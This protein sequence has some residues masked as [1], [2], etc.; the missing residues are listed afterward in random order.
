MITPFG[1]DVTYEKADDGLKAWVSSN[2]RPLVLPF[3]DR[4]ISS[5]FHEGLDAIT[6]YN[7]KSSKELSAIFNEAALKQK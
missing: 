6:L 1:D 3:D 5:V 4:T 7:V 2:D